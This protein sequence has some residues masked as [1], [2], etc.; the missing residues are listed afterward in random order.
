[1]HGPALSVGP[2]RILQEGGRR[3][4]YSGLGEGGLKKRLLCLE[5]CE[6]TGGIFHLTSN[7]LSSGFLAN[8]S[9]NKCG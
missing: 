2:Q 4:P 1:M 8:K 5:K 6:L 9:G 3:D 7:S